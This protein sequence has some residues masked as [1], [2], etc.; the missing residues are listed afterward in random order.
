VS[1]AI[2]LSKDEAHSLADNGQQPSGRSSS[3]RTH[4]GIGTAA[5]GGA[6]F[7]ECA[8][9]DDGF[10]SVLEVRS[11]EA[12]IIGADDRSHASN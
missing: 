1:G 11:G 12:E 6:L 7:L 10:S 5:G 2:S 4:R 3:G 8:A 9:R